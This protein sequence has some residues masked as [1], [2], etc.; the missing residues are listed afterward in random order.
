MS[1]VAWARNID[2]LARVAAGIVP[3]LWV[4]STTLAADD[5]NKLEEVIVT[6][7][8]RSE[9]VQDTPIAITAVNAELLEQRSQTNLVQVAAQAPNVNLNPNQGSFG[10]G[11][12]A[13]IRGV[14]QYDLNPAFE[15]GVGIYIDDVYYSQITGS[16]FDLLDVDRVEILR[17]PQGTLAGKNSIGGAVK[18]F[19]KRPDGNAGGFLE[20]TYGDLD[21]IEARGSANFAIVPEKLFMRVSG[22]TRDQDGYVDRIDFGCANPGNAAG[23]S[24]TNIPSQ[25]P[26]G[27]S[28]KVGEQGGKDY[29]GLRAAVRFTPSDAL[30]INVLGDVTRDRSEN[31]ATTLV[32]VTR[33]TNNAPYPTY[34]SDNFVPRDRYTTYATFLDP[35]TSSAVAALAGQDPANGPFQN[36]MNVELNSWGASG[37]VDWRLSGSLSL[38]SVTAYRHY[39]TEYGDDQD[40]SP[41][42]LAQGFNNLSHRQAS[43]E[44]RLNGSAF[45]SLLD[46]TVGGFYFDQTTIYRARQDLRY[47]AFPLGLDFIQNDPV[48]ADARAG[49][50]HGV[51]HLT[52][53]LNLT[54][55]YR[56]TRE[57]KDYHYS[58]LDSKTLT[59]A[60]FIGGLNGRVGRFEGSRSDYRVTLDYRWT[61]DFMTYVQYSTGFKGGGVNPR[62]FIDTQVRSFGPEILQA[63]ELGFKSTLLDGRAHV[64]GAIFYN[65]YEDIQLTLLSC[66]QFSPSPFFPCALP[67]NAGDATIKGAELEV[68]FNVYDGL[69]FDLSGSYLDFEYTRIDPLA[70]FGPTG[71][72]IGVRPGM[73]TPFTPEWKWSAGI[74]Y[75]WD[76]AGLG[77]FTPRVDANYQDEL[78]AN[79]V[80]APTNK[81]DSY[82]VANARFT[83]R[84]SDENWQAALEVLN[85][86]DKFYYVNKFELSGLVGSVAGLPAPPRTWS[87]SVRRNF[88]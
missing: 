81:V 53:K 76:L 68:D 21:R 40:V 19:S 33:N 43:Q 88:K 16:N 63:G 58:R 27:A 84:S 15:P 9:R 46:Y 60:F 28:C 47:V 22:V 1:G 11:M 20:A 48:E 32:S 30:D 62:P 31:P 36:P 87:V 51:W 7:Q 70:R 34:T 52:D 67:L 26:A 14:G 6:A 23:P 38:T 71:A 17:G 54:T 85:L 79:A 4:S 66:P 42:T 78:Y 3:S 74:Q 83:W 55:G 39:V 72:E 8:F 59:P 24:G 13:S 82:T 37:S 10:P 12:A 77:T 25:R 2:L 65:K 18:L 64:N 61:L 57:S 44:L 49:F 80:N 50:V 73:I 35:A 86:A 45:G 56:Y 75:E 5:D 29:W 69:S 41:L